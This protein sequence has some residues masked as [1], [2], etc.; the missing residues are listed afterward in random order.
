MFVASINEYFESTRQDVI[1]INKEDFDK[2]KHL[3]KINSY[4]HLFEFNN[5]IL[6]T[7]P[8]SDSYPYAN[9]HFV[10]LFSGELE[11]IIL[12][13]L[14]NPWKENNLFVNYE[15]ESEHKTKLRNLYNN[16]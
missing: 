4:I 9:S 16:L 6:F 10:K 2:I 13:K 12:N 14:E 1:I 7:L 8:N 5:E 11:R 3:G 15:L